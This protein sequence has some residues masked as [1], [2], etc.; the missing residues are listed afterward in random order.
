MYSIH[1]SILVELVWIQFSFIENRMSFFLGIVSL[2]IHN[3]IAP[4]IFYIELY[5]HVT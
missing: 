4:G 5:V 3:P 2:P 1:N